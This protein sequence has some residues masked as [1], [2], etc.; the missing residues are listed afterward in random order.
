MRK[1]CEKDAK[2]NFFSS[3]TPLFKE[4]GALLPRWD[5]K[6]YTFHIMCDII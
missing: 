2:K 3:E 6:Y 4:M 1:R 5:K